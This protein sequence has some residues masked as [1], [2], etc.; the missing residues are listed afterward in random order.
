MARCFI[1]IDAPEGPTCMTRSSISTGSTDSDSASILTS[2]QLDCVGPIA[3]KRSDKVSSV[4]VPVRATWRAPPYCCAPPVRAYH[5][6]AAGRSIPISRIE[7]GSMAVPKPKARGCMMYSSQRPK[8]DPRSHCPLIRTSDGHLH[9]SMPVWSDVVRMY[10]QLHC[11]LTGS[12]PWETA[13]TR[14]AN[15]WRWGMNAECSGCDRWM[16]DRKRNGPD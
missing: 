6:N 16:G 8:N 2:V 12:E 15:C 10:D 5:R 13:R 7:S 1:R 3:F 9:P 14:Q 11:G 4:A